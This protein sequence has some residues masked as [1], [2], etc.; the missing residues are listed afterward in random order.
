MTP[1][2]QYQRDYYRRNRERK[3][4]A[5]VAYRAANP[6]KARAAVERWYADPANRERRRTYFRDYSKSEAFRSAQ[7]AYRERNPEKLAAKGAAWRRA[8]TGKNCAKANGYRA[9]R[10]SR[11]PVWLSEADRWLISEVYCL[12]AA[13]SRATGVKHHVDH[14]LPLNGRLVSG[15][16]VPANLRVIPAGDN[17]RK[18]C[19]FSPVA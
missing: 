5:A 16:H 18:G 4:A 2:Q 7:A 17:A 10:A 11:E 14:V 8:N 1:E 6:D 15:L 19:Q 13:R 9:R 3:L 12:A